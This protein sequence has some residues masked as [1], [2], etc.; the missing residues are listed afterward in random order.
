M[1]EFE[2]R[3][4][5][6]QGRLLPPVDNHIQEFPKDDWEKEFEYID[7]LKINFIEWI[8]TKKS[9]DS[10]FY[11]DLTNYSKK[12]SSICC[13]HIIDNRIIDK[14][15][16]QKHLVPVC[17]FCIKNN[18]KNITVP[19]L[20]ESSINENNFD[21]LKDNFINL[22][23]FYNDLNFYFEID[24]HHSLV[25]NFI[26]SHNNFYFTYDTGN[27]TSSGYNHS[28]YIEAVFEH[29]GNVH[30][31]DRTI[32][33][34]KTVKPLFGNTDFFIIFKL[35]NKMNYKGNFTLQTAREKEG[36]ELNTIK[37]HKKIFEN[38][39]YE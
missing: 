35:L 21:I 38:L 15:F 16:I 2:R 23:N 14:N 39:F 5:I 4:G 34:P 28:E 30:L 27:L 7:K 20:E 24:A 6:I 26:S 37:E 25:K 3:L 22:A 33:P 13:D 10:L 32:N 9:Y 19:L 31:K 11:L 29:I 1:N 17:D 8:V 18:I 36:F 12:I